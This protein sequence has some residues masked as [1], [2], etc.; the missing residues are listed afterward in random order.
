MKKR[1]LLLQIERGRGLGVKQSTSADTQDLDQE[2]AAM[3]GKGAVS[4]LYRPIFYGLLNI[5]SASGIVFANKAVLSTFGFHFT[6]GDAHLPP[7]RL[8]LHLSRT[9]C[10]CAACMQAAS[11]LH[12]PHLTWCHRAFRQR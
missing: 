11:R 12:A 7:G 10:H 2:V 4:E 1:Q 9:P 8:T 6:I 5:V 3:S